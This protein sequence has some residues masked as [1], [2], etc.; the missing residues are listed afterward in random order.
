MEKKSKLEALDSTIK[1][2]QNIIELTDYKLESEAKL[3]RADILANQGAG[4]I[5]AV[6]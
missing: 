3:I 5:G 4:C 1:T 2:L 6:E